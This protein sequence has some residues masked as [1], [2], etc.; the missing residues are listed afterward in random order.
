MAVFDDG[1]AG[2]DADEGVLVVHHGN[3][4]LT[5]GP[6]NQLGHAG[7]DFYGNVVLV[8][9]DFHDPVLFG[10]AV[11]GTYSSLLYSL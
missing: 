8:V 5:G 3:E 7:V 6:V 1:P 9:A 4:I 2:D 10:L 11:L